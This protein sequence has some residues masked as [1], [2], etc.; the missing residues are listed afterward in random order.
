[1]PPSKWLR[2]RLI[3]DRLLA[4]VLGVLISP[5]VAL[6][7]YFVRRHDGGP[8]LIRVRRVG[9]GGQV[10][11]MWKLRSMCVDRHDGSAGGAA[12]TRSDDNRVTP[13]GARMRSLHLDE[14]PQLLNVAMGQMCLLGPRPEAPEYV[15]LADIE[16]RRVLE[17]PPGIA[18]PTQIVVGEWERGEID[19]DEQGHAYVD[20]VVPV[21]LAIDNWYISNATAKLDLT[22][23]A[24]LARHA[25]PGR[26]LPALLK[27][28]GR[29]VP[30]AREPL[31]H[32]SEVKSL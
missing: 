18:G 24:A 29:S 14:L 5:V 31:E 10:F 23:L 7:A 2:N 15:D 12:L 20:S 4:C 32:L 3:L 1:M 27:L 30:E 22:I 17:V 25:L 19:Q 9:Q 13:I 6:L 21:K 8:P 11:G 26:E 16:W 28:V